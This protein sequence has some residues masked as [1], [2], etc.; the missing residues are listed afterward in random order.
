MFGKFHTLYLE[1]TRNCNF[2]CRYCSSGSN[3]DE[4]FQDLDYNTI[5]SRILDPAYNLGTR[6]LQLSGGEFL[7]RPDAFDIL[8][9]ANKKGFRIAVTSNGSTLNEKTILK[10][11]KIVGDN[12]LISLGINS[13]D[14]DNA[15]TRTKEYNY[16]IDK[17]KLLERYHININISVTIGAFNKHSFA[18][19]ID[20]ITELGLP[21][22]RIPFTPRN[23]DCPGLMFDKEMMKNYFHPV[24]NS[25]Y[26]GYVSFVPLFLDPV[27]Y[28][29]ISGQ[30]SDVISVPTNPSVGCWVGAFYS[31]TPD[32][33]VAPC[34]L[35]GDN[36]SGGN[37][38]EKD[39]YDILYNSELFKT[40]TNRKN[41]KGKCGNC[42]FNFTCGGCRVMAYYKT[43]D[44]LAEDP[45]CFINDLTDSELLEK[46]DETEKN[47]K[48]YVRMAK[49]GNIYFPPGEK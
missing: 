27:K 24:L 31:I 38:L 34:P 46:M 36:I 20:K 22:N 39:L 9:Y 37:V 47:F 26:K 41:L 42:R 16:T 2:N 6:F 49:F 43:G 11:K 10:I 8:D 21:Y 44:Y 35:L 1:A 33:E 23:V 32:G 29:E 17:I 13:F 4:I 25:H 19:T 45:T 48:K 30:S 18:K 40:I 28:K 5:I 14:E 15:A 7:L 3:S 12:I